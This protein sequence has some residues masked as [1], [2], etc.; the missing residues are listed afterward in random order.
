VSRLPAPFRTEA[1]ATLL[2]GLVAFALSALVFDRVLLRPDAVLFGAWGDG[3][4]NYFTPAWALA[5]DTG[6]RFTGMHHPWGEHLTYTDAQPTLLFLLR[7]LDRLGLPVQGHVVGW[8]NALMLLSLVPAAMLHFRLLRHYRVPLAFAG[9]TALVIAFLSPQVHR[10]HGHYALGY[11]WAVPLVWWL[12]LKATGRSGARG[13]AWTAGLT[14]VI[15]AL[16]F[17]HLYYLLIAAALL[18]AYAV[19]AAFG[20]RR[21][22]GPAARA[23]AAALLSFGLAYAWMAWSDP[24]D[25]RTAAP[26]GFTHYRAGFESVFTP[27]E[28]PFRDL[29]RFFLRM[30]TPN[31]EG[32]AYVGL[33]GLLLLILLVLRVAARWRRPGPPALRRR[34]WRMALPEDLGLWLPAAGLVLLFSM[35]LPFRWGLEGLLEALPPLRQFRSPGRMAWAFY[36]VWTTAAAVFLHRGWRALSRPG[37]RTAATLLVGALTLVWSLEAWANVKH[38]RRGGFPPNDLVTGRFGPALSAAGRSPEDFQAILSLPFYHNGSEKLYVERGPGAL[39]WGM[40]AALETGLPLYD[41]ML[42]R[43]SLSQ[44]LTAASLVSRFGPVPALLDTLDGRPLLVLQAGG[45]PTDRERALLALAD[46]VWAGPDYALL[47]LPPERCRLGAEPLVAATAAPGTPGLNGLA[48]AEGLRPKALFHEGFDGG[49]LPGLFGGSAA[50]DRGPWTL[51]SGPAL[52]REAQALTV[53]FYADPR[54]AA[55]PLLELA[56]ED[57]SGTVL[58]TAEVTAKTSTDVWGPWIQARWEGVPPEG[59]A[60][61]TATAQGR[62]IRADELVLALKDPGGAARDPR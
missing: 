50:R 26:W 24:V 37:G 61:W 23:L 28:G 1:G 22:T 48:W 43:T 45:A 14:A 16:G 46:T 35:A 59:A 20:R 29:W 56:W 62:W 5:R 25:D 31:P 60:R 30:R 54:V 47:S 21:A 36:A 12:A 39:A 40:R 2:V 7:G 15:L 3:L 33:P 4:K 49:G 34:P 17:V 8:L 42:S 18:G 53:W 57:A 13:W 58:A 11:A 41:V 27:V 10:W 32:Y 19:V 9:W 6:W 51:A 38:F 52:S 44:T 55:T